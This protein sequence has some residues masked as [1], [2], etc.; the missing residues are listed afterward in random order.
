MVIEITGRHMDVTEAV[1][2]YA[3]KKV[4][5]TVSEFPHVLSVHV[6]LDVQKYR[7]IAEVVVQGKDHLHIEASEDSENMYASIDAVVD[8]IE[9]Q[10]RRT[11]E[12]VHN[13]KGRKKYGSLPAE[14]SAEPGAEPNA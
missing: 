7:H 11:R 9:K 1:K 13:H 12:K 6:I 4:E 2:E 5:R 10:L 14:P 3:Q 8:K